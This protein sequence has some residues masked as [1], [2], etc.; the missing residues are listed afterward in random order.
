MLE[1]TMIPNLPGVRA[2]G[3]ELRQLLLCCVLA[4]SFAS[5]GPPAAQGC[6]WLYGTD[7]HGH[8]KEF[9]GG[10]MEDLAYEAHHPDA[11]RKQ[12]EENRTYFETKADLRDYKQ[13][14]DYA[15]NLIRLGETKRAIEILKSIE[16]KRPGDYATAANLGT[17]YELAG[18]NVQ[19]LEWIKEA[20]R[21]NSRS[22]GGTEWLHVRILEAKLKIAEDPKW[23]ETHHVLRLEFGEDIIPHKPSPVVDDQGETHDLES[24]DYAIRYQLHERIGLVPPPDL[25]V[26]DLLADLGNLIVVDGVIEKALTAYE[27]ALEYHVPQP[28]LIRQRVEHFKALVAANPDSLKSRAAVQAEQ[29]AAIVEIAAP[30]GAV[31]MLAVVVGAILLVRARR[32]GR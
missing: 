26:G 5:C 4:A 20:I 19:A 10:I 31:F 13:L 25:I 23:L 3:T 7:A 17:A 28:N 22:H 15:A 16:Q 30:V 8:S 21:R 2:S 6:I 11:N 18:D 29:F 9:M 1:I 27:L 32:R 12:W 24:V 14:N